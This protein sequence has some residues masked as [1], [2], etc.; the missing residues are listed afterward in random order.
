V[1]EACYAKTEA[2]EKSGAEN[3]KEWIAKN[4]DY[5]RALKNG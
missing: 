5:I 4:Q 3:S 1:V 2:Y